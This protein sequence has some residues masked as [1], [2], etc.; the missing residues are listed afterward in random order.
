MQ[1]ALQRWGQR[2]IAVLLIAINIALIGWLQLPQ[3]EKLS[4][5]SQTASAT[6]IRQAVEAEKVQL[7]LLQKA[8]S[9]GFSNL[10]A[11][12]TFLKF[13]QYFGDKSARQKTDYSL[14]PDYF[15]VIVRRD[16]NFMQSYVFLSAS[17]SLFAGLPE[18]SIALMKLGLESLKPNI[19]PTSYLVWRQLGID[20]LLFAGDAQA[21]SQSFLTAAQW[22]AQSTAPGSQEIAQFSQRTADFLA[23]N[24][25]SKTAQVA[26]WAM[27]LG[28]APDDR[29]RQTAVQR[30]EALGG[31]LIKNPDGTFSIQSPAKN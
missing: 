25:N 30:I 26:V 17:S 2:F 13:L 5:Q 28:N 4:A 29:T 11:D 31:K 8:P 21:A 14:S 19:P 24:P 27:V 23:T 12:W 16:P 3:L 9:F 22:A 15:E 18:R 1:I 10:I 20:Q 6:E 7:S